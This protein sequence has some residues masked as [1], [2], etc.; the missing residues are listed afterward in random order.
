M[1]I[2][3][4]IGTLRPIDGGLRQSIP[5]GHHEHPYRHRPHH[6]DVPSTGEGPI[7]EA[8]RSLPQQAR[9]W[10][11]SSAKLGLSGRR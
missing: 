10:S 4:A 6:H 11:F 9:A 3:V 5:N 1:A 7:R 2:G 8:G